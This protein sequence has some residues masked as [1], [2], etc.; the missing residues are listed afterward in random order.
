MGKRTTR[1]E[2]AARRHTRHDFVQPAMISQAEA[3]KE[4]LHKPALQPIATDE[5]KVPPYDLLNE[6]AASFRE[7]H[8]EEWD[9]IR[10]CPLQHGLDAM[11]DIL[12]SRR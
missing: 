8:P 6:I 3:E 2:G 11:A 10:L 4:A 12:K 7:Q 5:T 1:V 9:N